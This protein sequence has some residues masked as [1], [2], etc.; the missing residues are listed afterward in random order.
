MDFT[1]DDPRNLS[2]VRELARVREVLVDS[3]YGVNEYG[4]T[5]QLWRG[6]FGAFSVAA[7]R[8]R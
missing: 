4:S 3:F 8:D 6:Y 5:D 1:L 7:R 2:R